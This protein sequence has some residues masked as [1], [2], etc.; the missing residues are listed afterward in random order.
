MYTEP[1]SVHDNES[2]RVASGPSRQT[3]WQLVTLLTG[4]QKRV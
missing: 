1:P 2:I 4:V 3:L